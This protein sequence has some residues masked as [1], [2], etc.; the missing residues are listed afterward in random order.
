MAKH[1]L[2]RQQLSEL[3]ARL[4]QQAPADAGS[5]QGTGRSAELRRKYAAALADVTRRALRPPA[6]QAD[7]IRLAEVL[8]PSPIPA[9]V[10]ALYALANG[11]VSEGLFLPELK[12]LP[13]P[14]AADLCRGNRSIADGGP[15]GAVLKA[16]LPLFGGAAGDQLVLVSA[17]AEN[18]GVYY[19][20]AD[21]YTATRVG[22]DLIGFF[23]R[24]VE[25]HKGNRAAGR[26]VFSGELDSF[27]ECAGGQQ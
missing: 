8:S 21:D 5:V 16:G 22:A 24:L 4:E 25:M 1:E 23:H 12:F 15:V 17:S 7:L 3:F 9:E 20:D 26:T 13:A 6:S 19:I 10:D 11:E 14:T 18:A 2:M 27:S